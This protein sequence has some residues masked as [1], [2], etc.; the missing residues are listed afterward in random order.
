M[1]PPTRPAQP[2]RWGRAFGIWARENEPRFV[3]SETNPGSLKTELCF[4]E[5]VAFWQCC[6][7]ALVGPSLNRREGLG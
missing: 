1:F 5:G 6:G 3:T 7:G 4:V 2:F